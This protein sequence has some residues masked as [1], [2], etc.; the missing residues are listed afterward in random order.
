MSRAGQGRIRVNGALAL[1]DG[2]ILQGQQA[3][4]GPGARRESVRGRWAARAAGL[5]SLLLAG[6]ILGCCALLA[7][8]QSLAQDSAGPVLDSGLDS[9]GT[10][11]YVATTGNDANTGTIDS[12]WRTIQKAAEALVA[13]DTAY[14]RAGV[15][16]ERVVPRNSGSAGNYITYAA[17]PGETATI[18]GSGIS[19]A[20]DL[21][22][23]LTIA[24]KSFIRVSGLRIVNAGP[25]ADNA[26]ILVDGSSYIIVD[27]NHTYNTVS[28]G[29]G[30]WASDHVVVDG[31]AVEHACTDIWQECL[32]VAG[33]DVFEIKNNHVF[34]CQE[35][36]ICAKDGASNGSVFRNQV[37]HVDAT[38]L[39]VDAWDKHTHDI[40]VFQNIVHD[41][42]DN[43]FALASE[44]GG[45]L[46]SIRVYNNIAYH[47]RWVGISVTT[48]GI[49]GPINGVTIVNNT[50]YSNSWAQWGGGILVDNPNAE[51]VVVRNN[52]V[53]QNLYF[54]IAV[55]P[56]CPRP[57]LA[58]DHN[59]VDGFRGTEGETWGD[60]SV[61][62]DPLFVDLSALDLHLQPG[63]PA[64]DRGSAVDAPSFDLDG[65]PR[66]WDGDGD[67]T[68]EHDI[69]AYEAGE[70]PPRRIYLP[71]VVRRARVR[72]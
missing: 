60:H 47:N 40:D 16:R 70:W 20:D 35:E 28:S 55:C 62:A 29:I 67:G 6:Q 36:G 4:M 2:R 46:E 11:C 58:V 3:L 59:L 13:G 53:S 15:Y 41:I 30:V 61:A 69:G 63:S 51:N 18:D 9:L 68:A 49:S 56:T 21:V 22:G 64:I 32:T 25:H 5:L 45:L 1:D 71:L 43:G 10:I 39:Y 65:R 72:T 14:I 66:P 8:A 12:P 31:N 26:G 57:S 44:S 42:G 48:N 33:T 19:L 38:G 24:D 50:T 7:S 23:L 17:Y 52:I 37:H 27:H 54:Q 34:D